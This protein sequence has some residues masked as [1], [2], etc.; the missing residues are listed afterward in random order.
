MA[1]TAAVTPGFRAIAITVRDLDASLAWYRA[2]L[3][4]RELRRFALPAADFGSDLLTSA[5]GTVDIIV[6]QAV[7]GIVQF[8]AFSDGPPPPP[9]P[10]GVLGPGYTHLCLQ[11][12]ASDPALPKLIDAGMTLVS[13]CD[14]R[15]VDL[16]GYGIRYAYGHDPEGRMVEIEVLDRPQRGEPAWLCHL[17]NVVCD[18]AGML[19]F[20]TGLFGKPPRN[21]AEQGGRPTFD[22]VAGIDDV[23]IRG[24]WFDPAGLELELWHFTHPRSPA[25]IG[26]RRLDDIG[27]NA[28]LFE[29]D[30]LAAAIEQVIPLGAAPLGPVIDLGGWITRYAVDPEGNLFGLQQRTGA[31]H[32]ETIAGFGSA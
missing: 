1:S 19:A 23:A 16:G 32:A 6:T 22:A 28:P 15:G 25:P 7:T 3:D 9:E 10:L 31:P 24:A 13:R 11:S 8:M 12:P 20:Y 29:V 4:L 17:A 18:H 2:A 21:T 14:E 5:T 26:R 30:D 27:Y